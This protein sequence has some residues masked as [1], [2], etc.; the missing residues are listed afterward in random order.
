M[1]MTA[2]VARL[3][4]GRK[5]ECGDQ[6]R[7]GY[8]MFERHVSSRDV[9]FENRTARPELRMRHPD[10]EWQWAERLT[11]QPRLNYVGLRSGS[12][13]KIGILRKS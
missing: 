8:E 3:R 5:R 2:A 11:A 10:P 9:V 4:P 7:A 6:R 1:G 12:S 13:S